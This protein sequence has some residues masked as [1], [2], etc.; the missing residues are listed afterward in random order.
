MTVERKRTLGVEDIRAFEITCTACGSKLSIPID[1]CTKTTSQCP[2][3]GVPW[4]EGGAAENQAIT[5]L[6]HAI[7]EITAES[8]RAKFQFRMEVS[9]GETD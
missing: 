1:K 4:Y 8:K 7:R 2:R 6:A 9:A 3:C 5:E